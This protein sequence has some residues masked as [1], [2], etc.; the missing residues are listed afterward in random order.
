MIVIYLILILVLLVAEIAILVFIT[1]RIAGWLMTGV[2]GLPSPEHLYSQILELAELKEGERLYDLGSGNARLLFLGSRNFG[3]TAVGYELS[4]VASYW[5][6]LKAK[7]SR[8]KVTIYREDFFKA[9]L[10]N[11]DVVFCYLYPEVMAKLEPKF[12]R[13]L[14]PGSRVISLA[15]ALPNRAPDKTVATGLEAVHQKKILVYRF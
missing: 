11:A 15:F 2:P 6:K 8:Q 13:E 1:G 5:S 9:D 14:R 12:E 7:L 10:S 3:A 4:P